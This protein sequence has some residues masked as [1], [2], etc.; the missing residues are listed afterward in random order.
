MTLTDVPPQVFLTDSSSLEF[1]GKPSIRTI[2]LSNKPAHVLWTSTYHPEA[3][4]I[5]AWQEWCE[6][7]IFPYGR[8]SF[9]ITPRKNLKVF[10]PTDLEELHLLPNQEELMPPDLRECIFPLIDYSWYSQQGYDGFHIETRDTLLGES[11]DDGKIRFSP[12]RSWDC[13]STCWF[14]YDWIANVE[15]LN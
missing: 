11:W 5:C 3:Y 12:F 2:P 14:H 13:E 4:H 7:N 10:R 6:Q 9:L 15:K 8:N 1:R